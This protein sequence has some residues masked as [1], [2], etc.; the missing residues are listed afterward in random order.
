MSSNI[1]IL[2]FPDSSKVPGAYGETL[3][4]QSPIK[5]GGA[6][7]KLLVCALKGSGIGDLTVDTEFRRIRSVTDADTAWGAGSEGQ[8]A[9]EAA[10]KVLAGKDGVELY[11][12]AP[13]AAGGAA[14]ATATI[15]ATGTATANG[16]IIVS[17]GGVDCEVLVPSGTV[18]NSVAALINTALATIARLP[19]TSGVATNVATLT[20]KTPGIRGNQL[21]VW[22][23]FSKAPGVTLALG[24]AGAAL[25]STATM[26]GRFFGGGSGT[27]TLTALHA[28]LINDHFDRLAPAQNDATSLAA[29]ESLIDTLAGPLEGRMSHLT[30]ASSGNFAAATSL[31]QTTLN[32]ER[33]SLAWLEASETHPAAIA[34]AYGA[35]LALYESVQPNSNYDGVTL[36]G[37][38]AQRMPSYWCA[39]YSAKQSALDVGVTPLL[40]KS[41]GSVVIV[42]AITTRCLDGVTPDYRTLDVPQ[43]VVPDK[44]RQYISLYWTSSF[45]VANPWVRNEPST[46]EKDPPAG[47]AYPSMWNDVLTGLLLDLESRKWLTNVADNL[48]SS[49]WNDVAARIMSAVPTPV[50]PLQHQI[51]LSIRQLNAA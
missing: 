25:T 9:A 38:R 24:G 31:A 10:L 37:V 51:G 8:N 4:G 34:A 18:Q 43:A 49:D 46:N 36:K 11:G 1:I 50:L 47:V 35:T 20:C 44:T 32:E 23:D 42:R 14:A 21:V 27:E 3:Y 29:W 33:A 19:A 2:G 17:V 30:T 6:P 13:T 45:V 26:I 28:A 7:L 5:F 48:P 16:T 12:C 41:D 22:V 39:L 15:T 40:S